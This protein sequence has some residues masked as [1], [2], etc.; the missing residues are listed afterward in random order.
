MR[1][2][3]LKKLLAIAVPSAIAVAA[4]L[5]AR[6][7]SALV[8]ATLSRGDA[9]V[10]P[11]RAVNAATAPPRPRDIDAGAILDRNPFDH[12]TGPLR[13]PA[14]PGGG[15]GGSIDPR[16]APPCNGVRA[17]VVVAA[18]DPDASFAVLDAGGA[19]VLR[20]RGGDVA[21]MRVAYVGSER[22]WLEKSSGELC[23]A[24]LFGGAPAGPTTGP[25]SEADAAP[26][27]AFEKQ[28]AGKVTRV[29]PTELH[30]DRSAVDQLLEAQTEL[31]R[32]RLSPVREGDRVVGVTVL[33]VKP[34]STMAILGFENG[35]RLE[36]LN[37][38]EV[39]S[40]D[41]ML[42]IYA[43]MKSGSM[44]KLTAHVVRK[45]QPMNLDFVVR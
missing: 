15:R 9:V 19:R 2:S 45:G 28:L 44:S 32:L 10:S 11:V 16:D 6:A 30:V 41:K 1:P 18:A 29:S 34:G 36:S 40:P 24:R 31:M 25:R 23:Q 12:V 3:V 42:E 43:L 5:E 14:D 37:G 39:T 8:S 13:R 27:G 26:S 33:G 21:G 7:I 22:A 17:V 35:D 38:I 20:K 4:F